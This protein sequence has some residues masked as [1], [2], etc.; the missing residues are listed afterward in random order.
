MKAITATIQREQNEVVR[1]EDVPALLVAGIAGSGKTSVLLQRI[2]Y[3]FYQNRTELDPSEVFLITPNP[4][5]RTYIEN[6]LPDMGE[7]N[8]ETLTWAEFASRVMPLDKAAEKKS[9]PVDALWRIDEAIANLEF[10]DD[11][12]RELHHGNVKLLGINQIRKVNAKYRNVPAGPHRATLMREDLEDAL[13]ARVKQLASDSAVLEELEGMTLNEQLSQ[14]GE[15]YAPVDEKEARD[16]ALRLLQDR[17]Q[18]AFRAVQD[19]A[20]LRIDRIGMRLLG[21]KSLSALEWVYLKMAITGLGDA[22]AKYVMIDEVQDYSAAQLAVLTAR[23]F[24]RAHFM[25]LATKTR[26]STQHGVACRGAE[27]FTSA[28]RHFNPQPA[29]ELPFSPESPRFSQVFACRAARAKISSVQRAA[30]PCARRLLRQR[31]RIRRRIAR[32]RCAREGKRRAYGH[33]GAMEARGQ[34]PA[35]VL[36]DAAD[37]LVDM[38]R[39]PSCPRTAP[40]YHA[41]TGKRPEFDHVIVPDASARV[42]P[43]DDRVAKP[44]VYHRFTRDS[45]GSDSVPRELY[46]AFF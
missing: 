16:F 6:V 38:E 33:R 1:H 24:R 44:P 4:I 2:A 19:D 37:G 10:E 18:G 36:G 20:W 41:A 45:L 34:A 9:V 35:R 13:E 22:Y 39:Q 40:D 3:L 21:E 27:V 32:S 26:Q 23:F 25:L 5:F 14:F 28:R 15:P 46:A 12:F 43:A 31:R 42:F 8:P 29:Y 30:N 17:Y 7:R 11:D